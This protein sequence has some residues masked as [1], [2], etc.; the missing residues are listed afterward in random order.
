LRRKMLSHKKSRRYKH[1][2]SIWRLCLSHPFLQFRLPRSLQL[3]SEPPFPTRISP[4]P[5]HHLKTQML[6]LQPS[7]V[8]AP[9]LRGRPRPRRRLVPPPL[10][11]APASIVVSSDEDAFTRCSGYLFEE[12]AATES[13]LPTAYDLPGI[14]AVYRRRPLLVLRRS[15]QIGTSFGRWFALRYLDRVNERADDMFEVRAHA[16]FACDPSRARFLFDQ[17]PWRVSPSVLDTMS[18]LVLSLQL[19]AAQLRRILLELGPV[20]LI[21]YCLI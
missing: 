3:H 11:S 6:L 21:S 15:L 13:E 9:A 12:G 1:Y 2:Y 18:W 8:P 20:C 7:A 10:A 14:A 16:P 4:D 5:P 19:R 17:I